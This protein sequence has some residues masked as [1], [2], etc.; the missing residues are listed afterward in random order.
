[1]RREEAAPGDGG[2]GSPGLPGGGGELL[3]H[4]LGGRR[5][6]Y[7]WLGGSF[8]LWL[9]LGCCFGG[10]REQAPKVR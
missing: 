2:L 1:V 6:F 3:C 8:P 7:R 10:S 4:R 5:G 9:G